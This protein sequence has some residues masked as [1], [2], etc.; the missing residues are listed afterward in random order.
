MLDLLLDLLDLVDLLPLD[1]LDLLLVLLI[2]LLLP[3]TG[4]G[5]MDMDIEG[6]GVL[7]GLLVMGLLVGLDVLLG[8]LVVGLEV[9][10]G[11][12][13]GLSVSPSQLKSEAG[14]K[15]SCVGIFQE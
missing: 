11:V 5:S 2:L 3:K 12:T 14:T 1:L 13:V 8:L 10:L 6:L 4:F 15:F 9:G 7:F